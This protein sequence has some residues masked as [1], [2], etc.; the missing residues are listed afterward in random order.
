MAAAAA[1]SA[2]RGCGAREAGEAGRHT[3]TSG[4]CTVLYSTRNVIRALASG[5]Y[6]YMTTLIIM[7]ARSGAAPARAVIRASKK[8]ARFHEIAAQM[9]SNRNHMRK[10]GRKEGRMDGL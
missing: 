7:S 10:E 8:H 4:V 2:G 1:A 3:C 6:V 9:S 5:V